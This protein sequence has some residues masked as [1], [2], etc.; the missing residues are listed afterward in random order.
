MY[1]RLIIGFLLSASCLAT[2]VTLYDNAQD[3]SPVIPLI[4]S[5]KKTIDI[6]VYEMENRR[7]HAALLDA[8]RE[9]VQIRILVEPSPVGARCDIFGNTS[10]GSDDPV[11][12]NTCAD[13]KAFKLHLEDLGG[14]FQ[15]FSKTLCGS[16][17]GEAFAGCFQHGKMLIADGMTATLSTGNFNSTSFCDLDE[18][19]S[20]CNRDFT[21]SIRTPSVVDTLATVFNLDWIGVPYD[22]PR[23]L[24]RDS[25]STLTI[26]PFSM[27]PLTAFIRS[28][29]ESLEIEEQYLNDPTMNAALIETANRGVDVKILV[30][31]Y[32]AFGKP[33]ASAIKR[34]NTNNK[35]FE[36]AG[37]KVMT[38]PSAIRINGKPGYL[39]SKAIV[40]DGRRAWVGSVNGSTMSLTQNREYGVFI[41][42][43][44]AVKKLRTSFMSDFENPNAE[45]WQDSLN[46]VNDLQDLE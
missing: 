11:Q 31:S 21:V 8:A 39:H 41:H 24:P 12:D 13:L 3:G 27:S 38:F 30:A 33:T 45:T 28:A 20:R 40:V 6:E 16:G 25:F 19:P 26:S 5:A 46:C 42:D 7:V 32:C 35:A 2:E 9:G 1:L 17:S 23:S 34:A 43:S 37:A 22:L 18:R 29:K 14:K 15:P 10:A 36:G 44:V 4:R